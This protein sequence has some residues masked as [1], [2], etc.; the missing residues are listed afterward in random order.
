MCITRLP[1]YAYMTEGN[2]DHKFMPTASF[3]LSNAI[4]G[5]W[6][7]KRPSSSKQQTSHKTSHATKQH[8]LPLV[9]IVP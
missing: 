8:L 3:Q 4:S 1:A 2:Y 5:D 9:G 6:N 7:Q